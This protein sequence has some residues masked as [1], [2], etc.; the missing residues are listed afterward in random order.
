ML[1]QYPRLG[2]D[3]VAEKRKLILGIAS[4]LSLKVID[5]YDVL[6]NAKEAVGERWYLF[7]HG[8]LKQTITFR[9]HSPS[10]MHVKAALDGAASRL[11][12]AVGRSA[13]L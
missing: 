8:F 13:D 9:P 4:E 12:T 5:P 2:L 11:E 10:T 1:I 3:K 7:A 6:R